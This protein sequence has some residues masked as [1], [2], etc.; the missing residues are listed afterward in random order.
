M[1]DQKYILAPHL[2]VYKEKKINLTDR[3]L[4]LPY[5]STPQW[6]NQDFL[7]RL[8]AGKDAA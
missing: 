4:F 6:R 3:M 7:L 8:G 2:L 1:V 5:L